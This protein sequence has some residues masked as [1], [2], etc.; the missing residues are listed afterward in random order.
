MMFFPDS[1]HE[2]SPYKMGPK[3]LCFF[4]R[5]ITY[6]S[7]Y[8]DEI[9][10]VTHLFSVIYRGYPCHSV[11]L[12]W[13]LGPPCSKTRIHTQNTSPKRISK[14]FF[15]SNHVTKVFLKMKVSENN[16]SWNLSIYHPLKLTV[17]PSKWWV[18]KSGISWLPGGPYFQGQTVSC[19]GRKSIDWIHLV[20]NKKRLKPHQNPILVWFC[21]SLE[22]QRLFFEWFFRKDYCF[23]RHLQ[24]TI[25]G[26]YSFY[27]L[28]LPGQ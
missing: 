4:S 28:W 22:V 13:F 7:T 27:G 6:N 14:R 12:N 5:V 24:S 9:S 10:P 1:V 17:R 20:G 2:A 18:S 26:D 19:R 8:R 25:Q 15:R 11:F 23:S 21:Q 16:A 3:K